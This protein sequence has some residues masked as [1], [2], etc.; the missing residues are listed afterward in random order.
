MTD[1]DHKEWKRERDAKKAE[2]KA[3]TKSKKPP[4]AP[5]RDE[6]Q[7][8]GGEMDGQGFNPVLGF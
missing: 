4:K 7:G 1:L 5:P 8:S 2:Q 6:K 3:K